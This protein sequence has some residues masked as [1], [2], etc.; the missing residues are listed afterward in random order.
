MS[1]YRVEDREYTYPD[2]RNNQTEQ[3]QA[4]RC[5]HDQMTRISTR[6]GHLLLSKRQSRTPSLVFTPWTDT[7]NIRHTQRQPGESLSTSIGLSPM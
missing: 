4:E 6:R 5:E 3:E 7:G 1:L 2:T